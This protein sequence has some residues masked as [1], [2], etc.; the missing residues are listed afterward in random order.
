LN[1]S[2]D[3][4]IRSDSASQLRSNIFFAD[5]QRREDDDPKTEAA[6]LD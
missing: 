4:N 1:D 3:M 6:L 5:V 2:I